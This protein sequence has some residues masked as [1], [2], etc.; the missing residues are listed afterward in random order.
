MKTDRYVTYITFFEIEIG[1]L[2]SN[3]LEQRFDQTFVYD[4]SRQE[5]TSHKSLFS[6]FKDT[7]EEDINLYNS[8]I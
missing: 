8:I 2:R 7:N 1:D 4:K 5:N 3:Y 6:L